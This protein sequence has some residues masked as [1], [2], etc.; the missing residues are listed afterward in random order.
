MNLT[1]IGLNIRELRI[2]SKLT[3]AKLAEKAGI[4]T[5]HLS[6]IETGN[7]S[8]S[9][10]TLLNVCSAL[11]TT[12]NNILFGQFELSK[13]ASAS[14]VSETFENLTSDEQKLLIDFSNLISEHKVNRK[15]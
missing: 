7:V 11:R 2:A 4:S 13:E 10:D 8:M 15:K 1:E 6:H 3:Q 12:P 5:V 9:L 14:L